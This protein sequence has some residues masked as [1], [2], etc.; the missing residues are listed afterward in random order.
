MT[1]LFLLQWAQW[2]HGWREMKP[3]AMLEDKDN[4]CR[5]WFQAWH[6]Q[7]KKYLKVDKSLHDPTPAYLSKHIS[8]HSSPCA[9]TTL[10]FF[11]FPH[12][13]NTCFLFC[14]EH[15]L[16]LFVWL[17]SHPFSLGSDITSS[18]RLSLKCLFKWVSPSNHHLHSLSWD[19]WYQRIK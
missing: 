1:L 8:N 18:M 13:S 9:S 16:K 3:K 2:E 6:I 17:Y 12:I 4:I 7:C 11:W 5:I 10:V 19:Q 14:F 15:S